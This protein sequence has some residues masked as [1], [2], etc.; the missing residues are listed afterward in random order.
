[1]FR[2]F[3]KNSKTDNL[4]NERKNCLKKLCKVLNI[5]IKNYIL[6]DIALTH[7][8]ANEKL[9]INSGKS[10]NIRNYNYERLEFLGDSILNAC[11]TYILYKIIP[12]MREG[13]L[14][15]LRSSIVDEKSLS[16][17]SKGINLI[18][19]IKLGNYEQLLDGRAQEKIMADVLEAI[20]G[21]VFIEN[22]FTKTLKFIET[23]FKKIINQRIEFGSKDFKSK[24]QKLV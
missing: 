14:S 21:V 6:L 23:L 18:E 13:F 19:Y 20:I 10:N 9:N 17:I 8:S 15:D 3:L 24:L 2:F 16:E 1:M 22:G 12:T 7:T 4:T 5:K 11:V